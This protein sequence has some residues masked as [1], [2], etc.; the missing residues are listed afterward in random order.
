MSHSSKIRFSRTLTRSPTSYLRMR[1]QIVMISAIALT[2][3]QK[4]TTRA[5]EA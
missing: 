2:K 5:E 1:G 3:T 4:K